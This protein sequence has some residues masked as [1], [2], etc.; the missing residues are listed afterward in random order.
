MRKILLP[1]VFI[2]FYFSVVA[3]VKRYTETIFPSST[4]TSNVVFDTAP[5]LAGS[6]GVESNTTTED[7][8]MDI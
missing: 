4:V 1:L 7:L 5:F 3:Q 8:I 2:F 6:Y